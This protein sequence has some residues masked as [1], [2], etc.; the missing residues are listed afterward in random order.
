MEFAHSLALRHKD[1]PRQR[2]II[3]H[4]QERQLQAGDLKGVGSQLCV[5]FEHVLA[6][7]RKAAFSHEAGFFS[8]LAVLFDKGPDG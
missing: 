1:E 3:H 4:E 5:E 8:V 7:Y 6:I 2:F